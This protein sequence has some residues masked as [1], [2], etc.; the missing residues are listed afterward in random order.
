[1][2]TLKRFMATSFFFAFKSANRI[3]LAHAFDFRALFTL[4]FKKA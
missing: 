4:F 3:E 2:R 1:M